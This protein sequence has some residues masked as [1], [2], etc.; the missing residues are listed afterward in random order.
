MQ[1]DSTFSAS[2]RAVDTDELRMDQLSWT[3][4]RD[5]LNL[6][7]TT[8]IVVAASIEQHGPHLPC[9]VDGRY[10]VEMAVRAARSLGRCLVAPAIKPGCSEHHMGFAGTITIGPELLTGM[11]EAYIRCLAEAGFKEVV[12]TSSHGGNFGPLSA[13]LPRLRE[14]AAAAGVGLTPV[15]DLGAWIAGLNAALVARG[16]RQGEVPAIQADLIETSLM[17]RLDSSVVHMERAEVGTL[18]AFDVEEMFTHGLKRMTPNGIL[19]DPRGANFEL[20]EAIYQA[21]EGYLVDAVRKSRAS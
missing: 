9:D 17:L 7:Y 21:L 3:S 5:L 1:S 2:T 20:G 16:I 11:V 6:G 12:L 4:I 8:V 10:G 18:S 19:G 14:S 15:L 13:A